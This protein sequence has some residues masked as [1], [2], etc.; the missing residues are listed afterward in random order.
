[1]CIRQYHPPA[2]RTAPATRTSVLAVPSLQPRSPVPRNNSSRK[3][4]RRRKTGS[5]ARNSRPL[6][7]QVIVITGAS[8]GIGLVTAREAARRGASVV[9]AAR[10]RRDL[11]RAVEE[12][13]AAGGDA[14]YH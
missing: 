7:E 5:F 12:I 6:H 14:A 1:M 4:A 13:R 10:N 9:L 3:R 8:S 11:E 2:E